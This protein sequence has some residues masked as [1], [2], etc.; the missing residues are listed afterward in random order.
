MLFFITVSTML[1]LETTMIRVIIKIFDII[2]YVNILMNNQRYTQSNKLNEIVLIERKIYQNLI[3]CVTNDELIKN[4]ENL[5]KD[6]NENEDNESMLN[7]FSNAK[8]SNDSTFFV[9]FQKRIKSRERSTSSNKFK[10][11]LSLFNVHARLHLTNMTREFETIMNLN[12]FADE[13]KHM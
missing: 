9:Q 8:N 2:A 11:L 10:K 12:V 5:N 1:S 6:A 13:M 4:D 7:L 3:E